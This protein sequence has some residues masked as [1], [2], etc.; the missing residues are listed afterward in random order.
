MKIID[1]DYLQN[2]KVVFQR[3]DKD[4]ECRIFEDEGVFYLW[5]SDLIVNEW[6]EPFSKEHHAF[7]R[8]ANLLYCRDTNWDEGFTMTP[9]EF[10][11]AV[12]E[13][14]SEKI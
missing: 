1:Y 9:F 4:F 7:A 10:D 11:S 12:E 8:F 14:F 6:V 2:K 5:W 3:L 13:L